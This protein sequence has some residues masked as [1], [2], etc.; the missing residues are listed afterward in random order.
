MGS[1]YCFPVRLSV[2]VKLSD[3]VVIVLLLGRRCAR[4]PV[5]AI[6]PAA[7]ILQLTPFAAEGSPLRIHRMRPT[8]YAEPLVHPVQPFLH[9]P[10]PPRARSLLE[11][12]RMARRQTR[13]SSTIHAQRERASDLP[14]RRTALNNHVDYI[15]LAERV[16]QGIC[17]SHD[18][19]EPAP[20]R[21][22]RKR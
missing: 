16:A 2:I 18:V 6:G 21:P 12:P 7:E 4:N 17:V 8:Q 10:H 5:A 13:P 9:S 11:K 15:E 3:I 22:R 20:R 14:R 19:N 1:S